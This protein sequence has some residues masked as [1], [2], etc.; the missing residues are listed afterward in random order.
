MRHQSTSIVAACG[1][2]GASIRRWLTQEIVDGRPA[3]DDSYQCGACGLVSDDWGREPTPAVIRAALIAEH[4]LAHLVVDAGGA[5]PGGPR[6][7]VLKVFR[8]EFPVDLATAGRMAADALDNGWA[9][10]R[11]EVEHLAR[12]LRDAGVVARVLPGG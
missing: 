7:R 6:V 12:L 8:D 1:G 4:G 3:W 2:C 10:T 11:V 9:G 5:G